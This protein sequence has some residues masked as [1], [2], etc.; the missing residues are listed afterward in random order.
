MI[1][2]FFTDGVVYLVA[3]LFVIL[4]AVWFS[5]PAKAAPGVGC[6]TI[7]WGFLGGQRR[8][9]CDG[10]KAADGSWMR[11]R[12]IYVPAGY[13]PS[14]T[15]CG[16]YSCSTSGGYY[17]ERATVAFEVYPVTDGSVL[18]DEPGWLPAGTVVVR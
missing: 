5:I 15:S 13:V 12:E 18:P 9:V 7:R 16:S 10:P 11:A 17:R 4:A 1:R 3:A 8:T 14:F 6:E 2:R